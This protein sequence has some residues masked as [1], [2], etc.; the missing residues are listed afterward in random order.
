MIPCSNENV[1]AFNYLH[2]FETFDR[3]SSKIAVI[4]FFHVIFQSLAIHFSC[5]PLQLSNSRDHDLSPRFAYS[6]TSNRRILESGNARKIAAGAI[7][8][9][10]IE[11]N[12]NEERSMTVVEKWNASSKIQ[13][14]IPKNPRYRFLVSQSTLGKQSSGDCSFR[15]L[16]RRK[17]RG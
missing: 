16:F 7:N 2:F 14:I 1:V 9:R 6:I 13:I 15:S 11:R 10:G 17:H 4:E 12:E 8:L 3:S 5:R